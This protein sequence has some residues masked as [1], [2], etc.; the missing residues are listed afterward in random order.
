MARPIIIDCDPGQDDAVA[1]LLAFAAPETLRVLGITTVAGNVPVARCARNARAI[2]E[3]AGRTDLRVFAGCEYPL[4]RDP[5]TAEHLHGPSGLGGVELPEPK[6]PLA[7]SHAV[8]FL[9]ATLRNAPEPVTLIVTGPQTNL[10]TALR[11]VPQIASKIERIVAMGG[12]IRGGNITP[13]AEFNIHVDPQAAEI[14]LG[15][16]VPVTLFGLD[17]THQVIATD[18]RIEA[19]RSL[20]NP[21]ARAVAD[22]L[23]FY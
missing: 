12:S 4:V 1:L 8:D 20:D 22:M 2:C 9:I 10:A 17:V 18:R 14:V 13:F 19:I 6:M 21:V 11:R 3:L 7:P 23:G 5:I 15:L 16:G